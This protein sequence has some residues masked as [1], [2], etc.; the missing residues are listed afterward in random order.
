MELD[1]KLVVLKLSFNPDECIRAIL[2][3]WQLGLRGEDNGLADT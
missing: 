3:C 1:G 2:S